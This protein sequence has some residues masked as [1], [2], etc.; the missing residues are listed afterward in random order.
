M[1]STAKESPLAWF[2][3]EKEGFDTEFTELGIGKTAYGKQRGRRSAK[4]RPFAKRPQG[5]QDAGATG[6]FFA[7]EGAAELDGGESEFVAD[8]VGG[9]G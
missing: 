3:P 1:R 9:F 8:M 2:R 5:K 4:I 7:A 6:L